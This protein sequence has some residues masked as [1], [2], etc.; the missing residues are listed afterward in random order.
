MGRWE[1]GSGFQGSGGLGGDMRRGG[2]GVRCGGYMGQRVG[3]GRDPDPERRPTTVN[4]PSQLCHQ[5]QELVQDLSSKPAAIF[6]SATPDHKKLSQLVLWIIN[7]FSQRAGRVMGHA[8]ECPAIPHNCLYSPI[9]NCTR[10]RGLEGVG[11]G[12]PCI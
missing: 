6:S 11:G 9:L 4:F 2:G 8:P 1:G 12:A 3:D 7:N 10:L 5:N